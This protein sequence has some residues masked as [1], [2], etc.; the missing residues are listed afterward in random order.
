MGGKRG[1]KSLRAGDTAPVR[2][3][4]GTQMKRAEKTVQMQKNDKKLRTGAKNK[5][6]GQ[7]NKRER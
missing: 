5:A 4:R 1:E 3:G 6:K 7:V 2:G